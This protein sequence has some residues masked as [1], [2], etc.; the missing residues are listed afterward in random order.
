M[1]YR[2]FPTRNVAADVHSFIS[3]AQD[4]CEVSA[5]GLRLR[6]SKARMETEKRAKSRLS[7]L[8]GRLGSGSCWLGF[9]R[10]NI[11]IQIPSIGFMWCQVVRTFDWKVYANLV[12]A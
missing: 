10:K 3:V 1:S 9:S 12:L 2:P 4:A 5:L 7:A 11:C 6:S 8:I